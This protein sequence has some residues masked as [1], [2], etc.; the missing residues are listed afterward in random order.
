MKLK[1]KPEYF[2]KIKAGT[3]L[4]DY[5]D[6]HITFVNTETGEKCIRDVTDVKMITR[7]ELPD[8]LKKN[9]ILFSDDVIVAYSLS[10]EKRRKEKKI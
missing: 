6:A 9:T 3:K 2:R 5:R 10:K 1:A 4:V 8:D 7:N